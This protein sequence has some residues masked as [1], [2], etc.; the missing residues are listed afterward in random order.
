MLHANVKTESFLCFDCGETFKTVTACPGCN[1]TNAGFIAYT[2]NNQIVLEVDEFARPLPGY[3]E[4]IRHARKASGITQDVLAQLTGVHI[5]IV[6]LVESE[7]E[8]P[9][10]CTLEKFAVALNLKMLNIG[11]AESAEKINTAF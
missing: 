9:K 6:R 8:T 2:Y 4:V 10:S 5:H 3:G 7:K 1:S 11:G